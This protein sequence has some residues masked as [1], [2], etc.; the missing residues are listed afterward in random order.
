MR[1]LLPFALAVLL[2]ARAES[3]DALCIYKGVDNARTTVRQEFADARWVVRAR[4]LSAA[5][6]VIKETPD[7]GQP[8]T[9][10][11]LQVITS[12]KGQSPQQIKFFT[13]RNS[14]GFYM[15]RG[16]RPDIGG[17]YLLFLDPIPPYRGQGAAER[18]AAF[19][20]YTCGQSR[21]WREASA[22]SRR[23][24]ESLSAGL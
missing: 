6:G 15:D 5:N 2:L 19:V 8:W 1:T 11:R 7:A 18:G 20:I 23:M 13:L 17:E 4:V 16:R 10:Y 14:G 22:A 12:Y 3:A 9:V 24:L 21:P